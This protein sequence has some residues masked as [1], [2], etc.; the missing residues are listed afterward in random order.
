[1]S[2]TPLLLALLALAGCCPDCPELPGSST[3]DDG[4]GYSEDMGDC[5]DGDVTVHPNAT[6]RCGDDVDQDCSGDPDDGSD[7]DDGDG[8]VAAACTGGDDCDDGDAAVH[9]EAVDDCDGFDDDC[10]GA[11]DEDTIVVDLGGGGD[12]TSIQEAVDAASDG[13]IVCV[14][15]GTYYENVVLDGGQILLQSLEGPETTIV[16]GGQDGSV[17]VFQYGDGSTVQG[18]TL[19]NGSGSFFDPD[20]D[21]A[22]DACGGG[23]FTDASSPT[24]LDLV[25]RGNAADDGAGIYV[26]NAT[27]SM[28]G[29]RIS[30][31]I[32][33]GYGGGLRLRHATAVS[34][35]AVEVAGNQARTG[36]GVSLYDGDIT[37]I[38]C[39]V[40]DNEAENNGG[41][42]YA[43][44]DSSLELS[45]GLVSGNI[46]GGLGGGVRANS[47]RV[48]LSGTEISE[49]QAD[50]V[51]GGVA[52]R[53]ADLS[54]NAEVHG[55]APDDIHCDQC[56]GC[57][58]SP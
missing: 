31:N 4:D 55:N 40:L 3:D 29:S 26:N 21:G 13:D 32:A 23:I 36:A 37:L 33:S 24:L 34:L 10:D 15:P 54:V 5:D 7:D 51:G 14:L 53:L 11:V 45:S 19:T 30:D 46:A 50:E 12:T 2:Q 6:E 8:F 47:S 38:D 25:I 43:G 35:E 22:L 17:L 52:C 28:S 58:D 27:L 39:E 44:T 48:I 41:G 42:F 56:S 16:D 20:N 49:N 9:P 18:F 57:T 1:M